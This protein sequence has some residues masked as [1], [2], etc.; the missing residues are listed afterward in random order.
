VAASVWR[1]FISYIYGDKPS[2]AMLWSQEKHLHVNRFC[3][4]SFTPFAQHST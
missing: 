1:L 4:T 3:R 2:S